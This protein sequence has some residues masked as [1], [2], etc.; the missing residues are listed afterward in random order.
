MILPPAGLADADA[1]IRAALRS[2]DASHLEI[3]GWGELSTTVGWDGAAVKPLPPFDSEER[4]QRYREL[5]D[6]YAARLAERRV[7]TLPSELH[8]LPRERILYGYCVQPRLAAAALGPSVL[9]AAPPGA[10]RAHFEALFRHIA[11]VVDSQTGFDAQLANWAWIGGKWTYFDLTTP[12]LRDDT[13]GDRLDARLFL[14]ALPALIRRPVE[15]LALRSILDPYFTLR[16]AAIDLLGNLL[17]ERLDRHLGTGL[18][19]ARTGL[20]VVLTE[21]DVRR[22][23]RSDARLWSLLLALRRID[24]GLRRRVLRRPYPFLL[25]GRIAR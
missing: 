9:A 12:L 15:A 20:G 22:H 19:V 17:K 5:F 24:R 11:A 10:A 7:P 4:W 21:A 25:P 6:E 18:E 23:Y 14:A 13:G 1:A 8:A 16:G 2:G 3:L